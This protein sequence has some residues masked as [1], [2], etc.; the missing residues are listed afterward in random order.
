MNHWPFIIAAYAVVIAGI[1]GL[2]LLSWRAMRQAERAADA[3]R[4]DR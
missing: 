2:S 3:L 4:K 1:G